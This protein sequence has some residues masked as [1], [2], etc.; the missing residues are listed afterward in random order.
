MATA[1]ITSSLQA[2]E[3]MARFAAGTPTPGDEAYLSQCM[4]RWL[5]SGGK[6]RLEIALGLPV[7]PEAWRTLQRDMW[8]N[9][10]ALEHKGRSPWKTACNVEDA[11]TAFLSRGP[12]RH[13]RDDDEPPSHA[14]TE[15]AG[16]YWA[17]RFNRGNALSAKQ[18][19]RILGQGCS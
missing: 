15:Q 17:S 14:T 7:S 3:C 6:Q 12:W 1:L 18:I 4:R 8:V 16:L 9:T 19:S 13:W 11:W 2:L 5:D 10:L